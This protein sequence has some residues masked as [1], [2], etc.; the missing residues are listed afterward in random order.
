[1]KITDLSV[2][3]IKNILTCIKDEIRNCRN[4]GGFEKWI[5]KLE[6]LEIKLK[7]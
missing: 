5:K 1:M 3:E 6:K 4:H 7:K 2:Q